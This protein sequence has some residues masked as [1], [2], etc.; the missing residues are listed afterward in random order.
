[1]ISIVFTL[2]NNRIIHTVQTVVIRSHSQNT[3]GPKKISR[4]SLQVFSTQYIGRRKKTCLSLSH[5]IIKNSN[6]TSFRFVSHC[7]GVACARP[8]VY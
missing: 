6:A 3:M 2:V 7:A 8:S 4:I 5:K 1:M